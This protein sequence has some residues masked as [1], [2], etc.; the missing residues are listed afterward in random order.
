MLHS[1]LFRP[2]DTS[3]ASK[4]DARYTKD[5]ERWRYLIENGKLE[6]LKEL[7]DPKIAEAPTTPEC[8]PPSAEFNVS[9]A[10]F[11]RLRAAIAKELGH[12]KEDQYGD[13][14]GLYGELREECQAANEVV[15]FTE[16]TIWTN[17]REEI[18]A[19]IQALIKRCDTAKAEVMHSGD[20]VYRFDDYDIIIKQGEAGHLRE[21]VERNKHPA[22]IYTITYK[23]PE[24]SRTLVNNCIYSKHLMV[25]RFRDFDGNKNEN[26]LSFSYAR[27]N[28]YDKKGD[29]WLANSYYT[30]CRNATSTQEFM[31]S[32]G[33]LSH[34]LA[35]LCWVMKG[36]ASIIECVIDA[37]ARKNG[38]ELGPLSRTE[39]LSW[40]WKAFVTPN[41]EV[42]AKWY[43]EKAYSYIKDNK[44]S[45]RQLLDA[46]TYKPVTTT[47]HY[48]CEL[49]DSARIYKKY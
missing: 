6:F 48:S 7:D 25:V 8:L 30:A 11:R 33:R 21:R 18:F 1:N 9:F 44:S 16:E 45:L 3:H 27:I 49:D 13:M 31:L 5:Q 15:S 37:A 42:Y 41:R 40:D 4:Q 39:K 47:A 34:L 26:W 2:A 10:F 19:Q 23:S 32:A 20:R 29:E 24:I 43:A 38:I 22:T 46:A 12:G 28:K 36:N 35:Q 14:S 17:Q